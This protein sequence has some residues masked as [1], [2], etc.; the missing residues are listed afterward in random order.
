M[1]GGNAVVGDG[2]VPDDRM[3]QQGLYVRVVRLGGEGI[4]EEDQHVDFALGDER[5]DLLVAADGPAEVAPHPQAQ[6]LLDEFARGAG[7]EEFVLGEL[8]AVRRGPQKQFGLLAIV[9]D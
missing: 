7:A 2:D 6:G 4:P 1:V 8:V 5:S 9:G 3:T